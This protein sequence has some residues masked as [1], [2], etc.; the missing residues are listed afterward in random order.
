MSAAAVSGSAPSPEDV[1]TR[2]AARLPDL[3]D[4]K[5]YAELVSYI[6]SLP[7]QDEFV[8]VAQLLGFLT[9]IGRDLPQALAE[10]R[11]E[12]R[13]LLAK[14]SVALQQEVATT[15]SYHEKLQERLSQL[16]EEIAAGVKPAAMAKTL[17][18]AFRQQIAATGLHE[19]KTVLDTATRDLKQTTKDLDAAITP[20][21]SKY[22][23]L[24]AK[25]ETQATKLKEEAAALERKADA[26]TSTAHVLQQRNA[27]LQT[28]VR[29]WQWYYYPMM[30][31]VLLLVG[32]F[33]GLTWEQG[34]VANLVVGL[35]AQVE[36]L[37]QT[38]KT[39]PP[40]PPPSLP[41]S[42]TP[43]PSKH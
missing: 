39:P 14:A 11:T 27:A 5:S 4:H 26:L 13:A 2:L 30:A 24:A 20:L 1:L 41:K 32:F 3:Q 25:I 34:Q 29:E 22:N 21:T 40:S 33:V 28:Q 9:L 37:Q 12:W 42:K 35:Q 38:L 6:R 7:P 43:K 15:G 36:E 18:E 10:E 31:L 16:P 17:G 23:T 19:T 8:K